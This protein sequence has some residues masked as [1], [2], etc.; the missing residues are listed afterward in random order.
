MDKD[1]IIQLQQ[2]QIRLLQ[3]LVQ[4]QRVQ[5]QNFQDLTKLQN[6]HIIEL[7]NNQKQNSSNSSKSPSSDMVK[8][9]RTKSLRQKS[10]KLVGGQ[11]GHKGETL[12]FS[13]TPT[14]TVYH[15]VKKCQGCGKSLV[16]IPS[17]SYE[18]RQIFDIPPIE[19]LV[20]EHRCEIKNCHHCGTENKALF[21][22]EVSQPVQYGANIQRLGIYFT[23]YQLLP[24]QRT[25]EM[26]NDL[27]N[28][29]LSSSFLV[30]NNKRFAVQLQPFITELK[31]ILSLQPLLHVDETGFNYEGVRNWL[32]VLCTKTHSLYAI[33]AKRGLEAMD[34]IGV[35]P[36]FKG[37]LMHDFWKPYNAYDCNHKL[38]NVHH[39][40]DLTFC[41]EVE[42]SKTAG[43]LKQMLL[44]LYKK[45]EEAKDVG[46]KSLTKAQI[47]YWSK[48][49]DILVKEGLL[50][51]PIAEK[52]RVKQGV[53]KKTKTQNMLL[54]FRDYKNEIL[55]FAK[56]FSIPFG[57]NIAEQAIRMMKIKQKIS[58]CFRSMQ[59]AKDF[60]DIRSYI[61]TM[62]KQ[63]QPVLFA[64]SQ[65]INGNPI[66]LM[67]E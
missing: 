1:L 62:K 22:E 56:N 27:F 48:K 25:V 65:A 2:N 45:V 13:S 38:C 55:S 41:E 53:V 32:H 59:G 43:K 20:T 47:N 14:E 8:V 15:Q 35:L 4:E 60:A 37:D 28:L 11:P 51:H 52:K 64:I 16:N 36:I 21:P 31:S 67:A 49:Y 7:R 23:Q 50:N 46:N 34:E 18:R 17:S 61:A 5:L 10:D 9:V 30:N 39:L 19:V 12:E 66:N 29:K 63:N 44:V 40:R 57:N 3:A 24:Y 54:R 33:H 58:G 42:K 6:L 26:F